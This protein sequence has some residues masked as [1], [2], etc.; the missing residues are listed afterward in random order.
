MPPGARKEVRGCPIDLRY[1]NVGR[2]ALRFDVEGRRKVGQ[3]RRITAGSTHPTKTSFLVPVCSA[4]RTGRASPPRAE[5]LK[6]T[7]E[8]RTDRGR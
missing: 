2:P 1:E 6:R 7:I 4:K 3:R 5:P 8:R